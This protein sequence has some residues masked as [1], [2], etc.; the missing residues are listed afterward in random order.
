MGLQPLYTM[1]RNLQAVATKTLEGGLLR[2]IQVNIV[3]LSS[4]S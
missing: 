4:G 2:I 1:G 3:L